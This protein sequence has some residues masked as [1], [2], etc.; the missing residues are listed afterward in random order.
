MTKQIQVANDILEFP[1]DMPDEQI[2]T[3]IQREYGAPQNQQPQAQQQAPMFNRSGEDYFIN[4]TTA[5]YL[6]FVSDEKLRER[7]SAVSNDPRGQAAFITATNP[8]NTSEGKY[9]NI[10][11]GIAAMTAKII[12]G[13]ATKDIDIG[14]L[15]KEARENQKQELAQAR[16]QYPIQSALI[17]FGSDIPLETAALAK[18]G[19][20]GVSTVPK[21][22]AGGFAL[23]TA[24]SV[25][26][27]EKETF[28]EVA[29]DA[30]T[31]GT[32]GAVAAPALASAIPAAINMIGKGATGIKNLFTKKTGEQIAEQSISPETARKGLDQL[33]T[34]P[35]SKPTSALDIQQPEFQ[36]FVKTV[37]SKYPQAKQIISDFAEK[38]NANAFRRINEDLKKISKVDDANTYLKQIDDT[39]K[40]LSSPLYDLAEADTTLIPKFEFKQTKTTFSPE[41]TTIS[42]G[43][44]SFK[45][46]AYTKSQSDFLSKFNLR[47]KTRINQ[48]PLS[49]QETQLINQAKGNLEEVNKNDLINIAAKYKD[50]QKDI[51]NLKPKS[52]LQ[53]IKEKGGIADYKGELS[54]LGITN[55]T[56][57]GLLRKKGSKGIGIDDVGQKLY[58]AGYFEDRPTVSKILDFIDKELRNQNT[59]KRAISFSADSTK[60][61]EARDFVRQA[62][63]SGIDF[64]KIEQ[65]KNYKSNIQNVGISGIKTGSSYDK[66][67]ILSKG[68]SEFQ[69]TLR[70]QTTKIQ[71][72]D[73]VVNVR[74]EVTNLDQLTPES[75]VLATKYDKLEN[76]KI[77]LKFRKEARKSLSDEVPDNSI[78]MLHK[79]RKRI[80]ADTAK[81]YDQLGNPLDKDK[82]RTNTILRK[83]VDSLINNVSP[84]FKEA[85]EVFRPF[86][87]RKQAVQ[88][89]LDFRSTRP[90]EIRKSITKLAVENKLP[91]NEILNDYQV[92]VKQTIYDEVEKS[93]KFEG[94][95]IPTQIQIKKIISNQFD[96]EQLKAIFN[97]EKQFDDFVNSLNQEALY[98]KTLKDFGL[99]KSQV[100]QDKPNFIKNAFASLISVATTGF[101]KSRLAVDSAKTGEAIL[102]KHYRGL[103]DKNA[104]VLARIF[105]NKTA[106]IQLLENIVR[107]ADKTQKPLIQEAIKDIYPAIIG[108]NFGANFG[109]IS[110]ISE[111]EAKE[112]QMSEEEI[113][114]QL[115]QQRQQYP[116]LFNGQPIDPQE[117]DA[118]TQQIKQRYLK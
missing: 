64:K 107:K 65:L 87:A 6:P 12:G 117:I 94:S 116:M 76:N 97:S 45:K 9:F 5:K 84:S 7:M 32:I 63:A 1:A 28:G 68:T 51:I 11:A 59:G 58:E 14:E 70:S 21:L 55:K 43:V 106:S 104:E 115:I 56:L 50:A 92:G 67:N 81:Q 99:T 29:Q 78:S 37:L 30:L 91:R 8:L 75:K 34:S 36:S 10:K 3:A 93:I 74:K 15:Y 23:G 71:E 46:D 85:D 113:R 35:E 22:A 39:Q 72:G 20:G 19:L 42:E 110:L 18:M 48:G 96:R 62:E 102:I 89:G 31:A 80:D 4:K 79:I 82:I 26:G 13:N 83:D 52:V 88:F 2:Q 66:K 100:E 90:D 16:K 114:R 98:N 108:G 60:Y 44:T 118:E 103:N 111:A 40:A 49:L 101:G 77:F 47:S 95:N 54:N 33:R 41:T 69:N 109:D 61:N 27:S 105:I 53:F 17:G 25:G 24:S 112:P 73:K 38:R 86:Q 57:P